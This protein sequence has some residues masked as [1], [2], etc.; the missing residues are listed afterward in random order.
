MKLTANQMLVFDWI[1]YSC[2]INLLQTEGRVVWKPVNAKDY[3]SEPKYKFFL[4][5]NVFHCFRFVF[6]R[7]LR[8]FNN[9]K[10]KAKQQKEKNSNQNSRFILG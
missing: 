5:R 6:L 1:A 8:L 2:Q 9:S 10:Q 3:K 7:T 4:Y